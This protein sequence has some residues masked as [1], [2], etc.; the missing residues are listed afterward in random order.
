MSGF[1]RALDGLGRDAE[2]SG[3]GFPFPSLS[4]SLSFWNSA[5]SLNPLVPA[6]EGCVVVEM[7]QSRARQA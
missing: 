5:T 7:R 2:R 6:R 3:S 4:P 1:F